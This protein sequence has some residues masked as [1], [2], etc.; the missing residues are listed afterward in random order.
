M[1]GDA[2]TSR[3]QSSDTGFNPHPRVEGDAEGSEL[4]N[5]WIVSI[6]T[7]AWRVTLA[8][9]SQDFPIPVSI[10]TLAWRVTKYFAELYDYLIVSIHTLAWRVTL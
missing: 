4:S 6:H 1:E 2:E 3:M 7:L 8:I 9:H 5:K 10:H